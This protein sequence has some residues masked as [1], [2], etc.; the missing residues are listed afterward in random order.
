MAVDITIDSVIRRNLAMRRLPLHY[1]A[2]MLVMAKRG[3]EEMHFDTLQKF[4][5]VELAIDPLLK[6][7]DLPED[8]VEE[9]SVGVEVADKVRALGNN[10]KINKDSDNG[11]AFPI[12]DDLN[13]VF[14][15]DYFYYSRFPFGFP[16]TFTDSY[17]IIR[18]LGKIRVDNRSTISRIQ[19]MYLTMPTKVSSRSLLHPFAQDSLHAWI[20]WKWAENNKD[21]DEL[22]H[23][24]KY[25]TS[26]RKLRARLNKM[27]TTD[28]KRV[29][30]KRFGLAVKI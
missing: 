10:D 7:A 17:T 9:I 24:R 8:F 3:L 26:Y 23:E 18:E 2:V 1:Y 19:L 20:N 16:V 4:K 25:Y 28:I 6:T 14:G 21:R 12:D 27:S 15:D 11:I 29:I 30:R 5:I 13:N 22:N